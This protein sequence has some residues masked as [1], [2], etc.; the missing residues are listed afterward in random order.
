MTDDRGHL[1]LTRQIDDLKKEIEYLKKEI[2]ILHENY[3]IEITDKDRRIIDL[4]NI[5][6]SHKTTNGDLRV[7]NNQLLREND[8]MKEVI[9][10]S[11]SKL[12]EN[13]EI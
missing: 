13:G 10:K 9:N 2:T 5:N 11:V 1:D 12:R 3:S 7:L 8:K 6:D 4:M